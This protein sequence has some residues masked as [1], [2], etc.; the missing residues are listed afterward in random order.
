VPEIRLVEVSKRFGR[1]EAID[2]LSLEIR[3]GEYLCVL[4]PTGSGKTTL[5]RLIAGLLQPDEGE[6]LIDRKRVNELPAEERDVAYMPQQYALFPHMTVLENVAFGP[7]SRGRDP[8]EASR[9]ALDML[10]LV[11]LHE[12][13][14]ALPSELSGGMQQRVALA[15]G[16]ASGAKLML[17]DEPLGALDAR[18]R[19]ELRYRLK[20]MVKS[21]NLTAIHVTHDQREA[22]IVAD[23]IVVLRT[24]RSEQIGT[25]FHVYQ[26]PENLFVANF[27]GDTNFLDGT[28]SK[29]DST[30]SYVE[31]RGGLKVRV[32]ETSFLTGERVI[33]TIRQELTSVKARGWEG[34]NA[35]PGTV[36]A[37]RFL[38]DYMRIEIR[39][40]NGDEVG[41]KVPLTDIDAYPKIGEEVVV[42]FKAFD[43]SVYT[44]PP[45][46]LAKE[47]EVS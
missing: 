26:R 23:R 36:Q 25:P 40:M 21:L 5:L 47:I 28:V 41:A 10:K 20:S 3:N 2:D 8:A 30:G 9:T 18:L 34:V 1:I 17:L 24:G 7:L 27:V 11:R 44:T 16:L 22:M 14:D 45:Q 15:R 33:L 6:I 42:S 31:L 37:V 39:L 29:V 32:Q 38:G 4:G 19:V 13:A 35:L 12:R 46:G 43:V